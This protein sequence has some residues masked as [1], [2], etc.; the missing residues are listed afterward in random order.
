M[1]YVLA[2]LGIAF[3]AIVACVAA[4]VA[5]LEWKDRRDDATAKIQREAHEWQRKVMEHDA[6]WFSEDP[7]MME[8]LIRFARGNVEDARAYWRA[9]RKAGGS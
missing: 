1:I 4:R 6:F 8:T 2:M 5:W 7:V 3:L 9:N